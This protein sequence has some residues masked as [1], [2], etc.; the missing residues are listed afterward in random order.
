M[1][2][3]SEARGTT[4]RLQTTAGT[5]RFVRI[6]L[7]TRTGLFGTSFNVREARAEVH[8]P[9]KY[10]TD[11]GLGRLLVWRWRSQEE[12]EVLLDSRLRTLQSLGYGVLESDEAAR[13]PWDWLAEL[14]ARQLPSSE[15]LR[16]DTAPQAS[17]D[18]PGQMLTEILSP[19]GLRYT[20][21]VEGIANV[22]G[23]EVGELDDPQA[24]HVAQVD[25]TQ[26]GALLPFLLTHSDP[27]L[28]MI[29]ERWLALPTVAYEVN[30]RLLH[31]WLRTEGPLC[32][33]LAERLP[34]EGLALL[35]TQTLLDLSQHARSA[36]V[37]LYTK[38][39]IQRLS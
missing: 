24:N 18:R 30:P 34:T 11:L 6:A 27:R 7:C 14:V 23:L 1:A 22:L 10:P 26:L 13:G 3:W 21:L 35:G 17:P 31:E 28:R 2:P 4:L 16:P 33:A 38:R 15:T 9:E 37:K 32:D 36:R 19:L 20:E 5:R 8:D 25:P 39:W 29:G 12:A